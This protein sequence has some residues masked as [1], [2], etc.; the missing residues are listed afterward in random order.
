MK[1]AAS[2]RKLSLTIDL[3]PSLPTVWAY[4][5]RLQQVVLNLLN[6]AFKFTREGGSVTLSARRKDND[7]LVEVSDT[8]IG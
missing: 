7:L 1:H 8:G 5:I 2:S 3:P 6:N 4:E